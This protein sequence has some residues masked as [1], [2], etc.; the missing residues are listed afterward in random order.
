MINK[1]KKILLF[2]LSIVLISA[3][4]ILYEELNAMI[5]WWTTIILLFPFLYITSKGK[6]ISPKVL[7]LIVFITQF[8]SVPFFYLNRN[9]YNMGHIHPYL[10]EPIE[11]WPMLSKVSLFMLFFIISIYLISGIYKK[12][13]TEIYSTKF[14]NIKISQNISNDNNIIKRKFKIFFYLLLMVGISI[15]IWMYSNSIGL[16][17][18]DSPKLP[19]KLTG[20]L[21]YVSL[22][23]IPIL[24]FYSY[25]KMGPSNRNFIS[26]IIL[27]IFAI[28]NGITSVSKG[29]GLISIAPAILFALYE[30]K[31]LLFTI[32]AIGAL[33][34]ASMA[35]A[36]RFIVY[37][38]DA[39]N[40][41]SAD[42]TASV[43]NLVLEVLNGKDFN[44]GNSNFLLETFL[45]LVNRVEGYSNLVF[46]NDYDLSVVTDIYKY[47]TNIILPNF[48]E[49]NADSHHMQWQGNTLPEGFYNGG[50]LLTNVVILGNINILLLI[51]LSFITALYLLIVEISVIGVLKKYNL[52]KLI[53]IPIISFQTFWFFSAGGNSNIFVFILLLFLI[54]NIIP[55]LKIK[56]SIK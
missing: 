25:W 9:E 26:V 33:I 54:F 49:V 40:K 28:I 53:A 3:L 35:S 22:F 48:Y 50:S 21:F 37:V 43:W 36:A 31:F 18:I 27:T 55:K 8:V 5:A 56:L 52:N 1:E 46:A 44:L 41:S 38:I 11:V 16:T 7:A 10:F 12:Y 13:K 15:K 17:G 23:I 30:K 24:I 39:N 32:S 34:G 2:L 29:A 45:T 19:Y 51:W 14:Y 47:M 4:M 42:V 6:Y 20:I